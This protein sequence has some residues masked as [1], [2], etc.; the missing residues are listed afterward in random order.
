MFEG[1]FIFEGL[2]SIFEA[3]FYIFEGHFL[4]SNT[5]I[6]FTNMPNNPETLSI[7]EEK[8]TFQ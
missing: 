2:F 7:Y 1:V 4:Q 3:L 6:A 8:I 5:T